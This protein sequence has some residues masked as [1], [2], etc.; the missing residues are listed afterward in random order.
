[1]LRHLDGIAVCAA[2]FGLVACAGSA[3]PHPATFSGRACGTDVDGSP[4]DAR[5]PLGRFDGARLVRAWV[6]MWNRF[7]LDQVDALFIRDAR[8]TYFSS[9]KPGL[10]A[11]IESLREHHR[12][13]GFVPG[14]ANR[15]SRLW[16]E[17]AQA[18][19]YG[20][21]VVVAATWFFQRA[22]SAAAQR[23]PVTLVL[24][25]DGAGCRIAHAHFAND[26]PAKAASAKE[27]AQ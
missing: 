8:L 3:S 5:D 6:D 4:D 23:G 14:G 25:N 2:T 17:A 11:G 16:L 12:G 19:T 15:G 26:P 21:A 22:G 20:S 13:F 18:H 7:D 9:E 10:I 1:V 24:V 27:A